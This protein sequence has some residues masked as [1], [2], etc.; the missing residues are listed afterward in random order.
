MANALTTPEDEIMKASSTACELQPILPA[1]NNPATFRYLLCTFII[2]QSLT[3]ANQLAYLMYPTGSSGTL[4]S[5]WFRRE[6]KIS[7]EQA[8][9]PGA[10]GRH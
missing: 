4:R 6:T 9:S 10:G 1:V 8:T 2:D 5:M 7:E 3:A